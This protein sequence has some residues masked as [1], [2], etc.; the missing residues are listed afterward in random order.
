MP[1]KKG[2]FPRHSDEDQRYYEREA[3]LQYGADAVNSSL[4]RWG[5]YSKAQ[6]D[7]IIAEGERIYSALAAA[8]QAGARPGDAAVVALLE[9]W[10]QHL[11]HFYEPTIDYLRGLGK[12]YNSHP[13]FIANFQKLHQELPAF[14]EA[15]IEDYVDDLE[16]AELERMLAEDEALA[17]RRDKLSR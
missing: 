17:R 15:V 4:E 3:R 5:S 6:Q 11:S 14:L 1:K 9:R 7:A 12:L 10:R 16:T 13:E 8:L 2:G